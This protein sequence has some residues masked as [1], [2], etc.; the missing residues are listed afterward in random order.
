MDASGIGPKLRAVLPLLLFCSVM[1]VSGGYAQ[2]VETQTRKPNIIFIITDDQ[3]WDSLGATGSRLAKTPNIDRLAREG[4]SFRNFFT[5]TPLCSPSRASFL[6]GRYAHTHGVINND[7]LGLDVISHTLMTFPRRLREAGYETAFI[8][9]WHMGPDDS[10]RPGFDHWIS[11]KGQGV[12]LDPVVNINGEQRQL[13]GYMTDWLNRWALEFV[14]RPHSKPFVLYL[15]HKAVHAPYLPAKRH[16]AL[17]GGAKFIPPASANDDLSGKPVLRRTVEPIDWTQLEGVTPEPPESRRGRGKAADSIVR[18]QLRCLAA[19]DDGVGM[20]LREL[21]RKGLLENTIIIFTSDNGYLMGEHRQFDTKRFAYEES[22]RVP[23]II[24]Y[25]RLIKAGTTVD[26][27][28]LNIDVAPTLLEL[29]GAEPLE[30]IHGTSFVPLLRDRH[31]KWRESF[32]AEYFMEK[33]VPRAPSWQAVRTARWK[34]I[35][36]AGLDGMDELY[37]LQTD[38]LEMRNLIT[39]ASAQSTL[40]ALRTELERLK[41]E[42]K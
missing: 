31:A 17:Y 4:A 22:I 30:E 8:G 39:D 23:F 14:E 25:P 10:R 21:K 37:D 41:R 40:T 1:V 33:V 32:M 28:T 24:R 16:E 18:D 29:A 20:L 15:S 2:P 36:Y 26:A 34:Y 27:L 3:R 11:F 7:K 19:V 42:T 9:K 12:Y 6:T 5:T 38:P 13:D 35:H